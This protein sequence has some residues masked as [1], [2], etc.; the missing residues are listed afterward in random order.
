MPTQVT[1]LR[2]FIASLVGLD[3]FRENFNKTL[4]E[5]NRLEALPL[6]V[7]FEPVGWE[8]NISRAQAK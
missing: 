6:G 7:M 2:V 8:A 1:K 3:G 5:Y 4:A